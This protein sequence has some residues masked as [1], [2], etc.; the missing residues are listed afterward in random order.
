MRNLKSLITIDKRRGEEKV[1]SVCG[2]YDTMFWRTAQSVN[3]AA[4]FR[5]RHFRGSRD[6]DASRP[7]RHR[8]ALA[9]QVLGEIA[10]HLGRRFVRHRVEVRE[11]FGQQAHAVLL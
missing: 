11:E 3:P 2:N 7:A 1:S 9:A 8:V 4:T 5:K 6:P 10:L